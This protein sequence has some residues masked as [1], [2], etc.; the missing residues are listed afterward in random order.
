MSGPK[1]SYGRVDPATYW[2][3]QNAAKVGLCIE[4]CNSCADRLE[5]CINE[6]NGLDEILNSII[7]SS[8]ED[9][10][11]KD[12]FVQQIQKFTG[13]YKAVAIEGRKLD[14][15]STVHQ[16]EVMNEK[17]TNQSGYASRD[18]NKLKKSILKFQDNIINKQLNKNLNSSSY[19]F[20][21]ENLSNVYGVEEYIDKINKAV[22]E[23]ADLE[24][25]AELKEKMTA[26]KA[27]ADQMQ[28]G[29][30]LHNFYQVSVIPFV[31]ECRDYNDF[32]QIH[33]A[34]YESLKLN[35]E[36]LAKELGVSIEKMEFS[37]EALEYYRSKRDEL[38]EKAIESRQQFYLRECMD[39]A[40]EELGYS[41]VG[42]KNSV[43][44]RGHSFRNQL[45]SYG[46]GT[47]VNVTF[48]E[49]GQITMELGGID[50]VDRTPDYAESQKLVEAMQTFCTDY[51]RIED[52]LKEKGIINERVSMMPADEDFAQIIN[53]SE[54]N[55]TQEI[56]KFSTTQQSATQTQYMYKDGEE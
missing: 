48:A 22:A 6:A 9:K 25:S 23:I 1:I 5:E 41:L 50:T 36:I 51:G 10:K 52:K 53:V 35:C 21:F 2:Q 13:K 28:N 7:V 47:A 38:A 45:Y 26:I 37:K 56:S 15:S 3:M 33:Y 17:L 44:R 49:D 18:L 34:E 39:S 46:E 4:V 40:M 42:A 43:D 14:K 55:L 11:K 16:A 30:F 12:E 19:Y 29:E 31:K 8:Y 32:Y 24:L 20:A 54:Y 27:K